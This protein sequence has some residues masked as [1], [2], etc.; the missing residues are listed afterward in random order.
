MDAA[1][2]R[3][4]AL[5][6]FTGGTAD[7]ETY[8]R[9]CD[10]VHFPIRSTADTGTTAVQRL[11]HPALIDYR[12]EFDW[13][14][15]W[16]SWQQ[17]LHFVYEVEISCVIHRIQNSDVGTTTTHRFGRVCLIWDYNPP[18]TDNDLFTHY[19]RAGDGE[20]LP[21]GNTFHQMLAP[22]T[23]RNVGVYCLFDRVVALPNWRH[24]TYEAS[25]GGGGGEVVIVAGE[26]EA[27]WGG[28]GP[29]TMHETF[30]EYNTVQDAK[31]MIIRVVLRPPQPLPFEL[32]T[33]NGNHD[34]AI[35]GMLKLFFVGDGAGGTTARHQLTG[36]ISYKWYPRKEAF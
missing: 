16:V 14:D 9:F 23:D 22:F 8:R 1:R 32:E 2:A 30:V 26:G 31:D 19:F 27:V 25:A 33:M 17:G 7:A 24:E 36:N 10:L 28:V 12:D 34:E 18:T 29:T 21:Q 15:G 5:S 20:F 11:D 6:R 3:S 4:R 35:R 13:T